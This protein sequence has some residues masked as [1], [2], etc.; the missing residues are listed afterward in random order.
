MANLETELREHE[1]RSGP[2]V[3]GAPRFHQC[4]PHGVDEGIIAR[5]IKKEGPD[6][7]WFT[8]NVHGD[9]PTANPAVAGLLLH[10][11]TRPEAPQIIGR[12]GRKLYANL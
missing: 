11:Q 8:R 1:G 7:L 6:R 5:K 9:V 4:L 3:E 10:V 2:F 12:Q